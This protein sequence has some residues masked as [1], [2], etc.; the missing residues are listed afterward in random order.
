MSILWAKLCLVLSQLRCTS[1]Y[2]SWNNS[3]TPYSSECNV[4]KL[5]NTEVFIQTEEN[6]RAMEKGWGV[7]KERNYCRILNICNI[8][9]IC[10]F[11]FYMFKHHVRIWSEHYFHGKYYQCSC[12]HFSYL[13]L[14]SHFLYYLGIF[15]DKLLETSNTTGTVKLFILLLDNYYW[16]LVSTEIHLAQTA[17][18]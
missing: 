8:F 13:Q 1:Y 14:Q 2:S 5:N 17:G 18:K 11:F 12:C 10:P 4:G 9:Q 15:W 16:Q 7:R 3:Y 6:S